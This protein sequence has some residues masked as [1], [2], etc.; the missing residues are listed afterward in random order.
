MAG[1]LRLHLQPPKGAGKV[2]AQADR[3]GRHLAPEILYDGFQRK[4]HILTL[5]L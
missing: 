5:H 1:C 2:L 4:D 3:K